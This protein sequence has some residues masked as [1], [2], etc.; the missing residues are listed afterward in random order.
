MKM[1]ISEKINRCAICTKDIML[2]LGKSERT[3]RKYMKDMR[4]HLQKN[5]KQFV[6]FD[7]FCDH[8]GIKRE[9]IE[10]IIR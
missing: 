2:I 4:T 9:E 1:S 8:S 3:A 7:E 5:D 6:T 10:R